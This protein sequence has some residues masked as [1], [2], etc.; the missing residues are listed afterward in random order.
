MSAVTISAD[1]V[2]EFLMSSWGLKAEEVPDDAPL[3]SSGL[4]DSLSSLDIVNFLEKSTNTPINPAELSLD[5][6]DTIQ[7]IVAFVSRN[8][9]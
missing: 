1:R 3:F 5:D 8:H 6:L 7:A 2:R 4:L 9:K